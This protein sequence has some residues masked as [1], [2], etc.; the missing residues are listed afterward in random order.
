MRTVHVYAY[1]WIRI[2]SAEFG[3]CICISDWSPACT[4]RP[5]GRCLAEVELE[6]R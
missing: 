1:H 3:Q 6:N 2:V 5:M 4:D